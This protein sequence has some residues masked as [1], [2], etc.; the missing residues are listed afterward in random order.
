MKGTKGTK[1]YD[2]LA[3]ILI[4]FCVQSVFGQYNTD[5]WEFLAR[6]RDQW[7]WMAGTYE[8]DSNWF[9]PGYDDSGW[10]HDPG[11]LGYGDG[12]DS[13]VTPPAMSLYLRTPFYLTDLAPL[14]RVLL[15]ADYDDGF[16]AYLNGYEICRSNLGVPGQR[17]PYNQPADKPH[18]AHMYQG[19]S[20]E[21]FPLDPEMADTLLHSGWNILAIQVH[22]DQ[23]MDD[24]S[25]IFDLAALIRQ[26]DTL[27][28]P[29]PGWFQPPFYTA[30]PVIKI[31]TG[32]QAIPDQYKI[33]ATLQIIDHGRRQLNFYND[34]PNNYNGLIGIE[35]RGS[36][37]QW[38]PKKPYSLETRDSSGQELNVSLLGMPK[39]NDWILQNPYS[40]KSLMRNFLIYNLARQMGWYATR[41]R[42]CE[43]WLNDDYRGVYVFMEQIKWDKNRVNIA[44]MDSLDNGGDSLTGGYIVKI[45]KLTGGSGYAWV[46]PINHF[47][48]KPK[49][50][51]FQFD[52]PKPSKITGIQA[53]YIQTFITAFEYALLGSTF[54]DPGT[55]Y[56]KY[57]NVPSFM[58]YFILNELTKDVDAYRLSTYL[59]KPRD[60]EGG[61]ITMGP[62]WDFNLGFGNAYYCEGW[63]P[64]GWAWQMTCVYPTSPFWWE[65]LLQDPVYRQQLGCRWAE[66][67][68]G[69]LDTLRLFRYI[70]SLAADLSEP[71]RRNFQ[72][73]P[74]LG[75]YIWPNWFI[76]KSYQAEIDFLKWWL[77]QRIKWLDNHMPNTG[78]CPQAYAPARILLTEFNYQ[79][80][81]SLN[82][83]D[84]IELYNPGPDTMDFS[85]WQLMDEDQYHRFVFAKDTRLAPGNYLVV[86]RD[87]G[88]FRQQYPEVP[89]IAGP[90]TWGLSESDSLVLYDSLGFTELAF[91]YSHQQLWGADGYG[92]TR[93]LV[94]YSISPND[95]GNWMDGCIGGSPGTA[96][97]PCSPPVVIS[98]INYHSGSQYPSGDWLELYNPADSVLD[99]SGYWITDDN[100]ANAFKIPDGTYLPSRGRIVLAKDPAQFL[101]AYPWADSLL[102]PIG[103]GL[104]SNGEALRV[105]DS[106]M[107][108]LYSVIYG[109]R[110]PWPEEA[111][112]YGYTLENVA[113]G[114][115]PENPASWRSGCPG[116]SPGTPLIQPCPDYTGIRPVQPVEYRLWPNPVHDQLI[117]T[118]NAHAEPLTLQITDLYGRIQA[119]YSWKTHGESLFQ[120]PVQNLPAGAWFVVCVENGQPTALLPFIKF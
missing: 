34:R 8:P 23:A 117:I 51:R 1:R 22:N 118:G 65:R 37:S 48:G 53:S 5:H 56:R 79:S 83:G 3:G 66:L 101:S 54:D 26:D 19:L 76:G 14:L 61:K 59:S 110:S 16:V 35:T 120:I 73:W 64:E 36:T 44:Q 60:S 42:F 102:G 45:D 4:F 107:Q 85:Y 112:G 75:K 111:N 113:P 15:V 71:S 81:A 69:V 17:P 96:Y 63:N 114:G 94:N 95:P 99:C 88:K 50:V 106:S 57:I 13:T 108:L 39:E 49:S 78:V 12:D 82:G 97:H 70:D 89:E 100:F 68:A 46:S 91:G 38:F 109:T 55:G 32:G 62:I 11:S 72:R 119:S 10:Q 20:P 90:F 28:Y 6:H 33:T 67:R 31:F 21:F 52:Y 105:F 93:E 104:S 29:T 98:E 115:D 2:L 80:D 58:D 116:G 92:R 25:A 9:K 47:Q 7:S 41:T 103:F 87:T 74:I 27:Y 77:G 18:E 24:L 86:C 84:W 43:V 40:D 30:L